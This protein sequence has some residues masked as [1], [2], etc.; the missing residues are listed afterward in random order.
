[1]KSVGS[2]LAATLGLVALAGACTDSRLPTEVPLSRE[3]TS[4]NSESFESEG[5]GV[6]Q[7]Y[8]AIGT[9]VS[10]GVQSDGVVAGSQNQAWAAQLARLAHRD[11]SLPLISGYGCGA[12]LKAPLLSFAR[13]RPG[14]G[15]GT[16]FDARACDPNEEGVTLPTRNVAIDGATTQDAL[17][18]TSASKTGLRGLQYARVLPPGQTQ[19]GAMLAQN[20][21]IVSVELG[22]NDIMGARNGF[23]QPGVTVFPLGPWKALYSQV[24][25]AVESTAKHAIVIALI[26]DAMDFPAFRTGREIWSQEAAFRA[27]FHV[28]VDP[29]CGDGTRDAD[30]VLFVPVRVIRAVGE[31]LQRRQMGAPRASL[32]CANDARNDPRAPDFVLTPA[33]IQ[34]TNAHLAQMNAFIRQ[35][36]D[37]RGFA[38]AELEAIY[39]RPDSKPLFDVVALMT[40]SQPYGAYVSLDGIH[41]SGEGARVLADAAATALNARYNLGVPLSSAIT[42]A[43]R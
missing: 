34:A 22:A 12:P 37:A 24:L 1:M 30:N 28:E 32:S 7:R 27:A 3:L 16:P 4:L 10:M 19:V 17:S 25:D 14:E 23:Y 43:S 13:T 21:K 40:S 9:S 5:A 39:G 2:T 6:F 11:L 20:P 33:D 42:F 15:A 8:V 35:Q 36:A 31:G 38:Y 29:A 26:A 41:P 18:S